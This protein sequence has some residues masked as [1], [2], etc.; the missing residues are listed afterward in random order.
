MYDSNVKCQDNH[1]CSAKTRMCRADSD[2]RV[3]IKIANPATS[4]LS[5][6]FSNRKDLWYCVE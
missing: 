5:L 1:S 3:E 4:S 2:C 6:P